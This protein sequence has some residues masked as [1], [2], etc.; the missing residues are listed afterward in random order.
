MEKN[1]CPKCGGKLFT[2]NHTPKQTGHLKKNYYFSQWE[3]CE[4]CSYV[5]FDEKYKVY[6]KTE[7]ANNFKLWEE[8]KELDQDF[9]NKIS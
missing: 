1:N 7:K 3:K 4:K 2:K 9:L 6:P 8:N 5:L